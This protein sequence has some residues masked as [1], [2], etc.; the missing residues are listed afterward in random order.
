[1]VI[2][3]PLS[4]DAFSDTLARIKYP[5]NTKTEANPAD[6]AVKY[7][8]CGRLERD[9]HIIRQPKTNKTSIWQEI[10]LLR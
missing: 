3:N 8:F 1:M 2:F 6:L 4:M 7:Y 5:E 9:E 10:G